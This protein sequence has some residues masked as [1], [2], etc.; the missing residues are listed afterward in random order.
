MKIEPIDIAALE[1]ERRPWDV[2]H[3]A[4]VL[5][6]LLGRHWGCEVQLHLTPKEPETRER[7][8]R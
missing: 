7:R 1:R 5:S 2:Q 8:G 4:D 3:M 6:G